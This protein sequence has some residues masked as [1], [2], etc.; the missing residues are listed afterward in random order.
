[1]N[2]SQNRPIPEPIQP[3]NLDPQPVQKLQTEFCPVC[4]KNL[5]ELSLSKDAAL[6]YNFAN[7]QC[8]SCGY[9]I[10]PMHSVNGDF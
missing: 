8:S 4:K 5:L 2:D 6:N 10:A 7:L 1:M 9:R 3:K